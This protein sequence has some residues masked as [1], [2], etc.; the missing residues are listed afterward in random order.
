MFVRFPHRILLSGT[1]FYPVRYVV[2]EEREV[3]RRMEKEGIEQ[4]LRQNKQVWSR[5]NLVEAYKIRLKRTPT[6]SFN[7]FLGENGIL[8][9][10]RY[11]RARGQNLVLWHA[12]LARHKENILDYGLFHHGGVFFAPPTYGLPFRLANISAKDRNIPKRLMVLCCIFD[13]SEYESGR[14]FISSSS[15]YRFLKRVSPD[16]IFAV[17][18]YEAFEC[19]GETIKTDQHLTATDFVRREKFWTVPSRNPCHMWGEVFYNTPSK[20]LEHYLDFILAWNGELTLFEIFNGV[21]INVK[22]KEAIP[23]DEV[24]KVI[25]RKCVF[26]RIL[27]N[28]ALFGPRK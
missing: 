24:V 11:A 16:V 20:W 17:V 26:S 2:V 7:A 28:Q 1:Y 19:V 5:F 14:D 23:V 25:C 13:T 27:G 21:Y 6:A 22:P 3:W 18:T 10:K 8:G 12:T 4:E 9:S 15:Q